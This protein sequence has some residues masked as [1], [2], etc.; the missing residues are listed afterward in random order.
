MSTVEESSRRKIGLGQALEK[1]RSAQEILRVCVS[2]IRDAWSG[3][4]GS[5]R[6]LDKLEYPWQTQNTAKQQWTTREGTSFLALRAP[7]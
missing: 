2:Q 5:A 4:N 7:R 6:A 3:S 1:V